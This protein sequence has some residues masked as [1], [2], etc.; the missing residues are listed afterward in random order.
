[1]TPTTTTSTSARP[2]AEAPQPRS[3]AAAYRAEIDAVR[4]VPFSR[5]LR[6]ELACG[7][8][9]VVLSIDARG[10]QGEQDLL[11]LYTSISNTLLRIEGEPDPLRRIALALAMPD[12]ALSRAAF[13]AP[14]HPR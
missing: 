13:S 1:M 11:A 3:G 5:L 4:G 10:A 9:T 14:E 8:A 12:R 2:P 7:L 6:T